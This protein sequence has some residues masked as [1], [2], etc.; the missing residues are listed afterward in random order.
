MLDNGTYQAYEKFDFSCARLK[1]CLGHTRGAA[2][3][4]DDIILA[5]DAALVH[6]QDI[7]STA[8]NFIEQ[9]L[10]RNTLKAYQ[11]DWR[12]FTAWCDHYRRV[13]LPAS[14]ETVILYLAHLARLGRKM[15][16]LDRRC[17]SI[18]QAHR[19]AHMV[20]PTDTVELE[21][22]LRG[23]RR[24]LG[25]APQQKAAATTDI[26]RSLVEHL[27]NK[28]TYTRDRALLV[29]GFAGAFRRSELVSLDREDIE[30]TNDGIIVTVRR[31]KTDQT[32]VGYVKGLPYGSHPETC[33]VR[34][35]QAWLTLGQISAGPLFRAYSRRGVLQE[36]RLDAADVARI[37]KRAALAAQLDPA[38]F[39]GHSLRAGFVTAAAAVGEP[40]Y[41]IMEQTGH[42]SSVSVRRYIRRAS[43]F[44]QN[45]ASNVGL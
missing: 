42:K 25:V 35:L 27:P 30:I 2:P 34:T 20:S 28:P 44:K 7:A 43:L 14:S 38:Q 39:S 4:S 33:P 10:A 1:P 11:S 15:S 6:L 18:K 45:P 32:G 26:L 19:F 16:T 36:K 12:D 17:A 21:Q 37:V 40:E 29:M 5:E 8:H 23:M 31:S 13:C 22:A 24:S 41:R 9:A 3:M